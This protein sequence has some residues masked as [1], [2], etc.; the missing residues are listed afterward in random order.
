MGQGGVVLAHGAARLSARWWRAPAAAVRCAHGPP[1]VGA[2][3][4][5]P[6]TP[7]R[8]KLSLQA[9]F[10]RAVA[11]VCASRSFFV[12]AHAATRPSFS[13]RFPCSLV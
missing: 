3:H 5:Y 12:L 9:V 7:T 1:R 10:L 6:R 13:V 8:G 2:A 11:R 4:P